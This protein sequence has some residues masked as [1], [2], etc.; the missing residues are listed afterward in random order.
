MAS[1]PKPIVIKKG[2][3]T[4]VSSVDR[5][6]YTIAEL[7]KMA[8][9]DVA[10]LLRQR[11]KAKTNLPESTGN[12]KKNIGTW[13]RIEKSTGTPMLTMGVYSKEKAK[14]K[15]LRFAF[16]AKYLELGTSKMDPVNGGQGFMKHIINASIPD[17]RRIEAQYLEKIENEEKAL[18]QIVDGE[19]IADD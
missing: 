15:G 5:C 3:V 1:A 17:I 8:L 4:Y 18:A 13:V 9:R 16:Y 12:L 2:E 7:S 19:E 6:E 10:K 11:V 14:Q